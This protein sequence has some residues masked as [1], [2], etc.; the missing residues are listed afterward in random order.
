MECGADVEDRTLGFGDTSLH[1]VA[2]YLLPGRSAEVAQRAAD[3]VQLLVEYDADEAVKNCSRETPA[4]LAG[5][6]HLFGKRGPFDQP[7][8]LTRGQLLLLNAPVEKAWRRRRLLVLCRAHPNRVQ[9]T[10]QDAKKEAAFLLRVRSEEE[11]IQL[12]WPDIWR[13]RMSRRE[14]AARSSL[15]GALARLLALE[16]EGLFRK[17]VGFL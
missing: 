14:R 15:K 3:L 12:V 1:L 9:L 11:I 5:I 16:E 17:I 8:G 2:P 7:G 4:D 10:L 13:R 6:G